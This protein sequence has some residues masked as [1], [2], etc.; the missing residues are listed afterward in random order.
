MRLAKE[1]RSVTLYG[2]ADK[3]VFAILD[4]NFA[5][6]I[7]KIIEENEGEIG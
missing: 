7:N 6:S 4:N 3:T 1:M 2:K 5:K